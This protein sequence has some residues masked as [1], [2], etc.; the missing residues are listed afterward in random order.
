MRSA[1][2][3]SMV[4]SFPPRASESLR[5]PRVLLHERTQASRSAATG[6]LRARRPVQHLAHAQGRASGTAP[7]SFST[8]R[9]ARRAILVHAD[10]RCSAVG[11]V[12]ETGTPPCRGHARLDQLAQRRLHRAQLFGSRNC[13]SRNDRLRF[14][15][16]PRAMPSAALGSPPRSRSSGDHG[17]R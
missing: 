1:R 5:S 15:P 8:F 17:L 9:R 11:G 13:T 14:S 6:R 16:R 2:S 7:L 12:T 4:A 3:T 10:P